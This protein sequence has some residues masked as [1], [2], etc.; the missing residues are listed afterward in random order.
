MCARITWSDRGRLLDALDELVEA[1][2]AVEGGAGGD[3][4]DEDEAFAVAD[5]LVAEGGVFFLAGCVED[6]EHAGLVVDDDLLAVGVFD[7]GVVGLDEVVEAEL[8]EEVSRGCV[9]GLGRELYLDCES[10]LSYTAVA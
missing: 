6:F 9:G 3:A 10:C 5:P 1:L 7:G 4:V 2:D 8:L